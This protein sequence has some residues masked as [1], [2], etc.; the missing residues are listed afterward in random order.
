MKCEK[1]GLKL[2]DDSEFCQNCGQPIKE[3]ADEN[4]AVIVEPIIEQLPV[5]NELPEKSAD[6]KSS[7]NETVAAVEE[8]QKKRRRHKER[9]EK[10]TV[11]CKKCGNDRHQHFGTNQ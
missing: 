4:E 11:F 7:S 6:I 9:K 1:C 2:P 5:S 8:S 10:P 3:K